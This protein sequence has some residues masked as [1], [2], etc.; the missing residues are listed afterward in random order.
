MFNVD[1]KHGRGLMTCSGNFTSVTALHGHFR[2]SDA[3]V[4]KLETMRRC[5]TIYTAA[6]VHVHYG[7]VVGPHYNFTARM[8]YERH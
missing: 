1:E 5:N 6:V 7:N 4:C 2:D 3:A 8:N